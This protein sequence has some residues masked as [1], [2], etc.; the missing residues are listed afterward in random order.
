ML[1]QGLFTHVEN[2]LC[3]LKGSTRNNTTNIL[4]GQIQQ[5][6][7]CRFGYF[8]PTFFSY[9][10]GASVGRSSLKLIIISSDNMAG[11]NVFTKHFFF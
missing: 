11:F 4:Y 7:W 2:S 6:M 5:S 3:E 9:F 8:K 10:E 1:M